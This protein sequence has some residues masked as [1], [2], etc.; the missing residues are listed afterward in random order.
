MQE[1]LYQKK[2]RLLKQR[3]GLQ[4]DD[5]MAV[6]LMKSFHG[7]LHLTQVLW[8]VKGETLPRSLY[9]FNFYFCVCPQVTLWGMC[10]L[11]PKSKKAGKKNDRSS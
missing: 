10:N 1:K 2:P 8:R 6:T 5:D 11:D 3:V 4:K 9:F 7:F